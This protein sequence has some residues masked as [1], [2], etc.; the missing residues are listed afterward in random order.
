MLN[1]ITGLYSLTSKTQEKVGK[2]LIEQ[3]LQIRVAESCTGGL[4]SSRL[5]D[6]SGSSN[7]TR[8]NF[9]TYSNQA[10][11]LILEVDNEIVEKYGAVSE[12]CAHAMAEGLVHKTGCDIAVCTTGIA[13]PTGGSV[14]KPV[15]LLYIAVATKIGTSFL[16]NGQ[17]A[18][19]NS[20]TIEVIE[21]LRSNLENKNSVSDSEFEEQFTIHNSQFTVDYSITVKKFLLNPKYNRKNMKFMFTEKALEMVLEILCPAV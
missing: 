11:H 9:V 17:Q 20:S 5:T 7:Y 3:G 15:G 13:G 1:L 4:L 19:D 14:E 6:V 2:L 16:D 12:E 8:A 21:S 10:K 18:A